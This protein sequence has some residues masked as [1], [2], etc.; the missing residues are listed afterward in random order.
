MEDI[1]SEFL[2]KSYENL[3]RLDRDKT[4]HTIKGSCGFLGFAKLESV[5]HVGERLLS[6][7]S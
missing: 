1:V 3:D 2:V 6:R 5:T 7:P 4:I